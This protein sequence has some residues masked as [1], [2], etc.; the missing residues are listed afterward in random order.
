[1]KQQ[2][3][4]GKYAS[5]GDFSY[6][7]RRVDSTLRAPT[8]T[9]EK[10]AWNGHWPRSWDFRLWLRCNY[11]DCWLLNFPMHDFCYVIHTIGMGHKVVSISAFRSPDKVGN[12]IGREWAQPMNVIMLSCRVAA[13]IT[14]SGIRCSVPYV[15]FCSTRQTALAY[16][17]RRV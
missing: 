3:T 10:R 17:S 4:Y 16:V 13:W 8:S 2:G 7:I 15:I 9:E 14:G 1:M 5:E 6:A 11:P 12:S